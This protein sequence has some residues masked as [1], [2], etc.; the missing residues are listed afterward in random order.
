MAS[1]WHN[2]GAFI[3]ARSRTTT[4]EGEEPVAMS[5]QRINLPVD[6][7]SRRVSTAA[8]FSGLD[9]LRTI[10]EARVR[11]VK[12]TLVFRGWLLQSRPR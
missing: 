1:A 5:T 8:R 4:K 11:S 3:H 9:V 6:G 7:Q 12:S 10:H 2:L